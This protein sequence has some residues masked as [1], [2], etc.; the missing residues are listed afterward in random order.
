MPSRMR[1]VRSGATVEWYW[2]APGPVLIGQTPSVSF[3][4]QAGA[5]LL[6]ATNMDPMWSPSG[7]TVS[8]IAANLQTVTL[9]GALAATAG[10]ASVDHGDAHMQSDDG[11]VD[12]QVA[13]IDGTEVILADPLQRPLDVTA[14]V[15]LTPAWYSVTLTSADV[16]AAVARGVV[17]RVTWAPSLAGPTAASVTSS[18][19]EGVL[20]VVRRPFGTGLSTEDVVSVLDPG[21]SRVPHRSQGYGP[22]IRLAEEELLATLRADLPSGLDEHDVDGGRLRPVHLYITAAVLTRDLDTQQRYRDIAASIYA[23][24][25]ETLWQDANRDGLAQD[26]ERLRAQALVGGTFT[27]G[28]AAR[29]T[30]TGSY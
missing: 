6:G 15:S 26:S 12:V 19:D 21:G 16:T 18:L 10:T 29:Y 27:A 22:A 23:R 28:A 2:R 20:D 11:Y 5:A 24:A 9:S 7:G 25:R 8:A 3:T 17:W 14:G 30:M 1:A 13:R 4:S